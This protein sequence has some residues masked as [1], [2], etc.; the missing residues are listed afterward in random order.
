MDYGGGGGGGDR[1]NHPNHNRAADFNPSKH[2]RM[3]LDVCVY[4]CV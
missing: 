2:N 1:L 3:A 4:V